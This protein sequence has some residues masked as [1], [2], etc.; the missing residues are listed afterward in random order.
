MEKLLIILMIT[1][2]TSSALA[3]DNQTVIM[4]TKTYIYHSPDCKWAKKCTKN[5]IK[6][7]KQKAQT[8][9]ARACKVCGG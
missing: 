4:N 7:T 9:G 2:L 1:F 5:C 6:T 8:Q 3:A